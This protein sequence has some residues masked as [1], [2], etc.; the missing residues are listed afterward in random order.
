MEDL[1]Q[2]SLRL[3]WE[4]VFLATV[5]FEPLD[6]A[7]HKIK[8]YIWIYIFRL[9]SP[10]LEPF[11]KIFRCLQMPKHYV[12]LMKLITDHMPITGQLKKKNFRKDPF[13][14]IATTIFIL[15]WVKQCFNTQHYASKSET[16][17]HKTYLSFLLLNLISYLDSTCHDW[18]LVFADS[19]PLP[20][21]F[22]TVTSFFSHMRETLP[23]TSKN[24]LFLIWNSN[25]AGQ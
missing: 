9:S 10:A 13:S 21:S 22:L 11:S 6:H 20:L 2:D 5:G 23:Q 18:A 16:T 14:L 4:Y 15:V 3:P 19:S 12:V 8:I 24:Y 25:P 1:L 17:Q 7:Y